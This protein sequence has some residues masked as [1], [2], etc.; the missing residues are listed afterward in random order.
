MSELTLS[1][2][3]A[4]AESRLLGLIRPGN[5]ASAEQLPYQ[6]ERIAA[7]GQD[8]LRAMRSLLAAAGDPQLARPV[9]QVAGTSGKGSTAQFIGAMLLAN[10]QQTGLHQTPYLQSPTEKLVL[11]NRLASAGQFESAVDWIFGQAESHCE[12]DHG[13]E[14]RYGSAWVAL[15]F[16]FFAEH[17][18]DFLVLE[19]GAGARFDLTNVTDPE[20]SVI[21]RIGLDHQ[22]ALGSGVAEIAWHKSGIARRGRPL[23]TVE[24]SPAAMAVIEAESA[25]RGSKLTVV[26]RGQDWTLAPVGNNRSA[27]AESVFTYH[28]A[29]FQIGP[30]ALQPP[31]AWQAENAALACAA[32]EALAG[33]GVSIDP[34]AA[35]K[36][37]LRARLQG[38]FE[39]VD[40]DPLVI[41]D[42]AHNRQKSQAL[43]GSLVKL[44]AGRRLVAVLGVMG[45]KQAISV[46]SPLTG[47]ANSVVF[48]QA[49]AHAKLACPAESLRG[50][51]AIPGALAIA[52]PDRALAEAK[53][54]AGPNGV[55]FVAGSLYLA[56]RVRSHWYPTE[57]VIA[58]RTPWPN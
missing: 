28:G 11:G 56:G 47:I 50:Q 33:Q 14:L 15:T 6:R 4:K 40:A 29:K 12:I 26:R 7:R 20:V 34:A 52:N 18:T 21:T 49:D 42:G 37:L 5:E 13:F 55:V 57:R 8:R 24:Q 43:A 35:A 46:L 2:Q 53:A 25:R 51:L 19:C 23:I 10:G 48:T 45:Y 38:R 27:G 1:G 44:A 31:S 32:V 22:R 17:P 41:L 9:V 3:V 16:G 30:V 36:G 39:V 54:L 58:Q